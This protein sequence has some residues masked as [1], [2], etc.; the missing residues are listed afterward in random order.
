[1]K[2]THI[3]WAVLAP[4][5]DFLDEWKRKPML[6]M[7]KKCTSAFTLIE[8]LVVIAIIT[9]LASILFPVFGRAREN[10]RRSS[11]QSNL[12]QIGIAI[13]QYTQD[14]DD[15]LPTG[16]SFDIQLG[17]LTGE[18]PW[19]TTLQP[20]IKSVQIFKCPSNTSTGFVARTATVAGGPDTYPRS[21]IC[22]G[23]GTV[24]ATN[25]ANFG[26][27]R[28]MNRVSRANEVG[29]SLA[30]I[31][32]PTELI[33]VGEHPDRGDPDFWDLAQIQFQS[34]LGMTNF[35]FADGHV[36]SMKPIATGTPINMWNMDNT[37]VAGDANSGPAPAALLATL[38][39]QQA[40]LK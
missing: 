4:S 31:K 22:N 33:L 32:S 30:R 12:K 19:H 25:L 6:T 35:L 37:T 2:S 13:L 28:P 8:L 36:K 29:V 21:Y 7:M 11:C 23:T 15:R 40:A 3:N 39:Q 17:S 1:M 38:S 34:H 18:R 27:A 5:D 26:G 9:I 24:V 14:Y 10:A 20:Y 16:Q